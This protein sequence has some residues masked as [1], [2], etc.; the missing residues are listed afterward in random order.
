MTKYVYGLGRNIRK[1]ERYGVCKSL[2]GWLLN[3]MNDDGMGWLKL[4]IDV[5]RKVH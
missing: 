2:V 4:L 5:A 3:E 1:A